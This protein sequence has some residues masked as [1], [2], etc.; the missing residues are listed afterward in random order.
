MKRRPSWDNYFMNVAN[1]IST[2][3]T[4]DRKYVGAVIV[5]PKHQILTTGYNG[6]ISGQPHCSQVGHKMVNDHCVRTI[7]AEENALLQAAK[8][9]VSL[10][11]G[12]LYSTASPCWNCF[13]GIARVG[14][15]RIV[16]GEMYRDKE[17]KDNADNCGIELV[18][19][20]K[21]PSDK[22]WEVD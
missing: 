13:R 18:D 6:S 17:I 12:I 20:S 7:H 11:G 2:R 16:F 22:L 4:C 14:I 21:L 15:K 1:V 9:G 8:V 10:E 3:G 5:D 19:F